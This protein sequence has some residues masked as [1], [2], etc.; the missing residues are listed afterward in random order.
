L[1]GLANGLTN[2]GGR[3]EESVTK[4]TDTTTTP[5]DERGGGRGGGLTGESTFERRG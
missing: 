3:T 2:A 4:V 5:T 1:P